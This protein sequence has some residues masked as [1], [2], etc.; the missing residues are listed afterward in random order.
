MNKRHFVIRGN[1]RSSYFV[2]ICMYWEKSWTSH[3]R[4]KL[5]WPEVIRARNKSLAS[6]A[7]TDH[8]I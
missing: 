6:T 5:Q 3:T 7:T 8:E 1:S 4:V 2:V